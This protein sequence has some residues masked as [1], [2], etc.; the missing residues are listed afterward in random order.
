VKLF[1][2]LTAASMLLGTYVLSALRR[3]VGGMLDEWRR[4]ARTAVERW[5]PVLPTSSK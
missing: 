2:F 5:S 3:R 4:D 1:A